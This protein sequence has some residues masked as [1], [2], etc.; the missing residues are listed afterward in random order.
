L[1]KGIDKG[2]NIFNNLNRKPALSHISAS[3]AETII[4]KQARL[5]IL[6]YP[7]VRKLFSILSLCCLFFITGGYHFVCRFRIAEA[8]QEM[9]KELLRS[10]KNEATEL[11][12]SPDEISLLVWEN[13]SEFH[14]KNEMYDVVRIEKQDGKTIICCV[15]DKKEKALVEHYLKVQKQ[16][17]EKNNSNSVL[18]LLSV[19]FIPPVVIAINAPVQVLPTAFAHYLLSIPLS[20]QSIPTPPPKV[21]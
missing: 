13:S 6:A 14:Y 21:C 18:K 3:I 15:S 4:A 16:S 5:L 7:L 20:E 8:K 12:L 17:S 10:R 19:R 2:S 1:C 9:K 11:I